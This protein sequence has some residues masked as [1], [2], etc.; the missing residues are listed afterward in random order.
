VCLCLSVCVCASLCLSVP[1]CAHLCLSACPA[2]GRRKVPVQ[3]LANKR[4][5][6]VH[7]DALSLSLRDTQAHR[8]SVSR[9]HRHTG[10]QLLSLS[11]L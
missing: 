9:T 6:Q 8:P 3:P 11:L 4:S 1:A 2:M 5:S 10:M 7:R